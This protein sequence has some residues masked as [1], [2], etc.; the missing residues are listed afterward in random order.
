VVLESRR[1]PEQGYRACLGI[2]KLAD[3]AVLEAA[4]A[5]AIDRGVYSY[6]AVKRLIETKKDVLEANSQLETVAHEHIRGQEYYT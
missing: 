1:H 2:L 3:P 4:C 5:L 6:R